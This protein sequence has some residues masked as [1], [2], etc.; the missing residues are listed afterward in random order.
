MTRLSALALAFTVACVSL[1]ALAD[2]TV[3]K[4]SS[5]DNPGRVEFTDTLR[6][7]CKAVGM[8][9]GGGAGETMHIQRAY[10]GHFV[11]PGKVNGVSVTFLVDTGASSVAVTDQLAMMANLPGGRPILL[12][13]ANGVR[14]AQRLDNVKVSIGSMAAVETTVDAGFSG[15]APDTALLG[16]SFLK[17]YD[18]SINGNDMMLRRR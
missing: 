2:P 11:V 6:P 5:P 18:I 14:R 3:Y 1:D 10:N 4:C 7:G 8:A 16:Q 13:T 15:G 17:N 12:Q 9:G